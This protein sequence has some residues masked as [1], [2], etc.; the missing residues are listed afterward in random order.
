MSEEV[1]TTAAETALLL[2]EN[3]EMRIHEAVGRLFGYDVVNHTVIPRVP[4]HISEEVRQAV[5]REL[6][7]YV[8]S[9]LLYDTSFIEQLFNQME[10][11]QHNRRMQH[12]N[13]LSA[14]YRYF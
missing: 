2:H 13:N 11:V 3:I 9:S 10:T 12:R 6:S 1:D 14:A 8:A 7:R 4:N 5:N